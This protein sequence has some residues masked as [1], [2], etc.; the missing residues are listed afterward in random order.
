L[1]GFCGLQVEKITDE[2][3]DS[4]N[5]VDPSLQEVLSNSKD[6]NAP[7]VR[8]L[9]EFLPNTSL[10]P[11][12]SYVNNMYIYPLMANL[13]SKSGRN[14]AVRMEV[15][16]DDIDLNSPGLYVCFLIIYF[17]KKSI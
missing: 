14:F 3:L 11:H 13:S 1:K 15:K 2:G 6:P 16:D 12:F 8:E 7:L 17:Y 4:L 5:R 10:V 9:H